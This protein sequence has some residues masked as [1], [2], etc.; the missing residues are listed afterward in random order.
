MRRERVLG[1]S[2]ARSR[3]VSRHRPC[4]A[5]A[6][7][8]RVLRTS[9]HRNRG[10]AQTD[11]ISAARARGGESYGIEQR[12]PVGGGIE[13]LEVASGDLLHGPA[14][15]PRQVPQDGEI[16]GRHLHP[17][18]DSVKGCAAPL[19][20]RCCELAAPPADGVRQQERAA[21]RLRPIPDAAPLAPQKIWRH[22]MIGPVGSPAW[23]TA[24]PLTRKRPETA[25]RARLVHTE[26][27]R[28]GRDIPGDSSLRMRR[29]FSGAI[30][31]V[32]H[33]ILRGGPARAEV[34]QPAADDSPA[35][36]MMVGC[37]EAV[38]MGFSAVTRALTAH[39]GATSC[40]VRRVK[41][42]TQRAT[43]V[44]RH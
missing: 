16:A 6:S 38:K 1:A 42:D 13:R 19:L 10:M 36:D 35:G 21:I 18:P 14:L 23:W 32:W 43:P 20:F 41:A 40:L 9:V 27:A 12:E 2:R 3:L 5:I 39:R 26:P 25:V 4:A 24:G 30:R 22:V 7:I 44:G 31:P 17:R 37:G 28:S 34:G 15:E 11:R 33:S 29:S 8:G